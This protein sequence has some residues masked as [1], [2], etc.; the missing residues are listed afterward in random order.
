MSVGKDMLADCHPD[1]PFA[2]DALMQMG[3]ED[4]LFFVGMR[5]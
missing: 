2:W 5:D 4:L 1:Q 3:V